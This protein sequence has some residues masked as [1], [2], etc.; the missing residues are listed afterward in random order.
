MIHS[1]H[2]GYI[3]FS[4][5]IQKNLSNKISEISKKHLEKSKNLILGPKMPNLLHFWHNKNIMSFRLS[6]P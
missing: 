3:R 5:S 4:F 1:A 2:F 6:A